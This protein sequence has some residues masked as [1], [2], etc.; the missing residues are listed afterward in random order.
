MT[1]IGRYMTPV[2]HWLGPKDTL[3]K[4]K[5][6]MQLYAVRHLPV[7]DGERIAGIVTLSDLFVMEAVIAVDP[8]KTLV[9]EAMSKDLYLVEPSE[10][11][12]NVA[13]EMARRQVGSA[14][15]VEDGRLAGIFTSTDA[16]RV[17]GEILSAR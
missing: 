12:A 3:V 5:E 7:L 13:R 14:I 11:L 16:C 10:P 6:M 2:K 15:V 8:D 1:T 4:A 9:E 17:L